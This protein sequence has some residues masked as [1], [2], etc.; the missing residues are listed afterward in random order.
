M[1]SMGSARR[2]LHF[3]KPGFILLNIF[4]LVFLNAA[5]SRRAALV[6]ARRLNPFPSA[7][8]PTFIPKAIS[9][10]VGGPPTRTGGPAGIGSTTLVG[11]TSDLTLLFFFGFTRGGGGMPIS[12]QLRAGSDR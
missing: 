10:I 12:W 11:S 4:C 5:V 2:T 7:A 6:L 8:M 9:E 3:R 1:M